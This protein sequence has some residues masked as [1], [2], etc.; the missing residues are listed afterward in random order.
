M[1]DTSSPNPQMDESNSFNDSLNPKNIT[2]N[3]MVSSSRPTMAK[4]VST[5]IQNESQNSLGEEDLDITTSKK[6]TYE[7]KVILL[8]SISVGKTS[9]FNRFITNK[10]IND[11]QCTIKAEFKSK[12]VNINQNS[13]AKLRIW[14]TSGDERYRAI[15]RQYYKDAQGVLLVYDVTDR[16]SF[17]GLGVW[18]TE[19]RDNAPESCVV[20]LAG[21]KVD[22]SADRDVSKEEGDEFARNNGIEHVEV[23]AKFGQNVFLIFEKLA[24]TMMDCIEN[25]ND[26]IVK[27]GSYVLDKDSSRN[28]NRAIKVKEK[29]GCC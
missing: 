27:D 16:E 22:L 17:E 19:I 6:T 26:L 14:D 15:T 29:S 4:L 12:I 3:N 23:S 25:K 24:K 18:L 7:F 11:Y 21:N 20:L 28:R 2:M 9:I 1:L 10:F 13:Q 8:G 5:R